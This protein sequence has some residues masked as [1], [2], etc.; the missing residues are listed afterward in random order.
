MLPTRQQRAQVGG[1]D[2]QTLEG[3]GGKWQELVSYLCPT[4]QK[5]QAAAQWLQ[6]ALSQQNYL[7]I[8]VHSPIF[9]RMDPNVAKSIAAL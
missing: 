3:V 7:F 2:G 6:D 8:K 9:I 1:A 4:F 5:E